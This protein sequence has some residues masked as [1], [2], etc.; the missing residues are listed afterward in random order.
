MA[1]SARLDTLA[2]VMVLALAGIFVVLASFAAPASAQKGSNF[3][4]TCD[5]VEGT[6]FADPIYEPPR[7]MAHRHLFYGAL[8]VV[9]A[10][11]ASTLRQRPEGETTCNRK[12]N[13]SSYWHPTVYRNREMLPVY[14]GK[15]LGDNTMYYRAGGIEDH[16]QIQ[17][18]PRN[19]E[20]VM[21]EDA[22]RS[23]DVKWGCTPQT[24]TQEVPGTCASQQLSMRIQ[25][26]QCW[27]GVSVPDS[28][29]EPEAVVDPRS[30]ACPEGYTTLPQITFRVEF[31]LPSEEVGK[32]RVTGMDPETHEVGL[33]PVSAMHADFMNGWV[34][35]EQTRLVE[36]CIK[37]VSDTATSEEK[38]AYCR[39]PGNPAG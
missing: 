30:G 19:F 3:G 6:S 38:P 23:G 26:P 28:A 14:T 7:S 39:D 17:P 22:P 16:S 5:V 18:F 2:V 37:N 4:N 35:A 11:T 34:Q 36:D 29:N 10:D 21:R 24:L 13:R 1:R 8:D 31:V 20:M 33:Q 32:I 25:F 12:D 9:N 15:A 27:D